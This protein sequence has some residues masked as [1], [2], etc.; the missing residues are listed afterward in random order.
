MKKTHA[1][2]L[3]LAQAYH[4]TTT[5]EVG[6]LL[7]L[8]ADDFFSSASPDKLSPDDRKL[9]MA[10]L[11]CNYSTITSILNIAISILDDMNADLDAA[12][13][14]PSTAATIKKETLCAIYGLTEDTDPADANP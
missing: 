8:L 6:C 2:R 4:S 3:Q 11:Q 14:T 1:E 12:E 9:L 10:R 13:D 7:S 5:Y